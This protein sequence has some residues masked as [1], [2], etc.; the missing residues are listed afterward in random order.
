MLSDKY[1][2]DTLRAHILDDFEVEKDYFNISCVEKIIDPIEDV[3]KRY[4]D[5][6]KEYK[7]NQP[8]NILLNKAS[9]L[10][11]HK[12]GQIIIAKNIKLL[13]AKLSEMGILNKMM[14]LQGY[15]YTLFSIFENKKKREA[16]MDYSVFSKIPI[17]DL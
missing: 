11:E 4:N 12:N 10:I 13:H 7:K 1:P 15:D 17:K 14:S 16:C 5:E 2:R 8:Q 6:L 3:S 9:V